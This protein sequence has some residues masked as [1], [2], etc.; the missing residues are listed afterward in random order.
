MKKVIAIFAICLLLLSAPVHASGGGDK[1]AP[2]PE[3]EYYQVPPVMLPVI[4]EQGAVQQVS[5]AI[6]LEC[7]FGKKGELALY[8]PRLVDAYISDL[9]AA[10]GAGHVMVRGEVVDVATLKQRLTAVTEKVLGEEGKA[11]MRGLLIQAVQQHK[12]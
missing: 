8:G 12:I 3:F 5:L 9:F 1:E 6:S 11:N 10:L 7:P 4:N 2:P